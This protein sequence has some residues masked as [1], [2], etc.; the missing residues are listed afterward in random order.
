MHDMCDSWTNKS[1]EGGFKLEVA[2]GQPGGVDESLKPFPPPA[3]LIMQ[4][5]CNCK[6]RSRAGVN[7]GR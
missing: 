6:V 3:Q 2:T 7:G 4:I 5:L 1:S